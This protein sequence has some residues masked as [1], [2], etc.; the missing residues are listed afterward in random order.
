MEVAAKPFSHAWMASGS[1][2]TRPCIR[3][4]GILFCEAQ[5]YSVDGLMLSQAES[6]LMVS[7]CRYTGGVFRHPQSP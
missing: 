3:R 1:K 6:S 2:R 7:I 4:Q 5:R